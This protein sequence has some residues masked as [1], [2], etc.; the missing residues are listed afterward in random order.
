VPAALRE[1]AP[2]IAQDELRGWLERAAQ[3]I[4]V[5][6]ATGFVGK[7]LME[8]LLACGVR[9]R[10]LVR[11]AA[12]LAPS[13]RAGAD[14]VRGDLDD[15][16]ALAGLVAGVGT[17]IHLA[18]L[19]RAESAARFDRV[20]RVGTENLVRALATGAPNACLVHLSSLAAAG[21]SATPG[22]RSPEEPAQPIS[23]YGRSKL[24]AE[25]AV[26][27]FPGR[28]TVLR[29]PAVYGPYD[30]DVFQF[31]R[32]VAS[33]VALLP[34]GERYLTVAHVSDVVRAVL[35]SAAGA[36]GQQVLHLGESETRTMTCALELLSDVGGCKV[37]I[38]NFPGALFRVVGLVG[39]GLQRI[40]FRRVAITSDKVTELLARHWTSRTSESLACLGLAG[41]VPFRAGAAATWAWYRDHA[42]LPHAKIP[43]V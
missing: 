11:D 36:G 37:R 42:W 2:E 16:G 15:A 31:F 26:R 27:A 8:A 21:P 41:Y 35:A 7:N 22:G 24:G 43:A 18:G 6:G 20:N 34:A 4:A 1:L 32:M 40:G 33:G 29:P 39:D 3:P 13:A 10:V 23:K 12:R 5:T 9:P 17:A 14:I 19:V 28:W 25:K 30:T 38:V